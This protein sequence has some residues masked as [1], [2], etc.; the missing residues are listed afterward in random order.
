MTARAIVKDYSA[1]DLGIGSRRGVMRW[2]RLF[3]PVKKGAPPRHGDPQ[4]WSG[5]MGEGRDL[6]RSIT[7]GLLCAEPRLFIEHVLDE[8]PDLLFRHQGAVPG[9]HVNP[10]V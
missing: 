8:V 4:S 5:K 9:H 6:R 3:V 2:Q 7:G 1:D 10:A